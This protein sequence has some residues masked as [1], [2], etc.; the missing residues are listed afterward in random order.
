MIADRGLQTALQGDVC[1]VMLVG[2]LC[3]GL[4][5]VLEKVEHDV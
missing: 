3:L 5:T 2:V 1:R 4:K